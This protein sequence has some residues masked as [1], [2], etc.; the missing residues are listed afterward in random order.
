MT[1]AGLK[2]ILEGI[3]G[4]ADKVTY[5][6]WPE[7]EAPSLPFICFYSP[8]T[9]NFYAD[10]I[11]YFSANVI[12]VELYTQRRNLIEEIKVGLALKRAGL[13]FKKTNEFISTENCFMTTFTMEV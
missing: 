13:A 9:N 6:S 1:I 5:L 12:S 7:D 11:V 8:K 2:D 10:G 3:T 4:Y